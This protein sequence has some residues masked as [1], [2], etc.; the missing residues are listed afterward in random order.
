MREKLGRLAVERQLG[1]VSKEPLDPLA[2]L[3][4]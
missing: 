3:L 2:P 1:T 4:G